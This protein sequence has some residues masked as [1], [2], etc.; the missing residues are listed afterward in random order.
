MIIFVLFSDYIFQTWHFRGTKI[1]LKC[2]HTNNSIKILIT[3]ARN[4][5]HQHF[6]LMLL[7]EASLYRNV[8]WVTRNAIIPIL[9]CIFS[10]DLVLRSF[11]CS[12]GAFYEFFNFLYTHLQFLCW[13]PSKVTNKFKIISKILEGQGVANDLLEDM[14]NDNITLFKHASI[15]SL[16]VERSFSKY[17]TLLCE[18][19]RSFFFENNKHTLIV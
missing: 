9:F 8:I 2:Y 10:V 1:N 5:M 16:E 15:I 17:K 18:N 3:S 4:L 14:S 12:F 11:S 7:Y 13:K 6:F 19:R